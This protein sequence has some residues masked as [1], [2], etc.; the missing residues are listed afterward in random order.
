MIFD[1]VP[2]AF[3]SVMK[4]SVKVGFFCEVAFLIGLVIACVTG[5]SKDMF[6]AIIFSILFLSIVPLALI[7]CLRHYRVSQSSVE[8]SYDCIRVLD[9]K[10]VCW[11]KIP[12]N[13]IS[14]ISTESI[15]GFFYGEDRHYTSHTYIC[16]FLNGQIGIPEVSYDKLFAHKDFFMLHYEDSALT[17]LSNR[18]LLYSTQKTQNETGK[19]GDGSV[20]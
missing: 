18:C 4:M 7:P 16:V 1:L 2:P 10:G 19:T 14:N 11:R 8:F 15:S 5:I 6:S 17:M 20:S 3:K 13:T 12:Y 9:R